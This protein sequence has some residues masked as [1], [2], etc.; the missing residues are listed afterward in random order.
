[1][2][3]FAQKQIN[4]RSQHPPTLLALTRQ[5]EGCPIAPN[6]LFPCNALMGIKQYSG[7][8]RLI[9]KNPKPA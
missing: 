1:M 9:R 4:L 3:I 8:C 2:R 7:C 6:L 5:D